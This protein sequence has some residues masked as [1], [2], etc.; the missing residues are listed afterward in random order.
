MEQV[1]KPKVGDKI[2][3]KNARGIV[4]GHFYWCDEDVVE[5]VDEDEEDFEVRSSK[6]PDTTWYIDKFIEDW[7]FEVVTDAE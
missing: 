4:G 1:A 3:I 5:I 2:R 6:M 7:C